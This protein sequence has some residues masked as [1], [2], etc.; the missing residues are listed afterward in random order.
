[1]NIN[2]YLPNE[3]LETGKLSEINI[4]PQYEKRLQSIEELEQI[5]GIGRATAYDMVINQHISSI[6]M[7]KS[8]YEKGH[9]ELPHQIVMGLKYHG[10]FKENIPRGEI[11]KIN[12]FVQK[13]GKGINKKLIV[14]IS[15][16]YRRGKATSNDIDILLSHPTKNYTREFVNKLKESGFIVD[17]LTDKDYDVKYMGF[18]KFLDNPVRR[19]DI[20][21]VPQESYYSALL[22]FTGPGNFNQQIR[23]LA[24]HLGY[25]LN[26]YG[27]YKLEGEKRIKLPINSEKDIFDALGLEY[28]EP[29]KRE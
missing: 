14:V 1:M 9:I 11:D 2:I 18:S 12:D 17:D 27:L 19:L 25:L 5:F 15:G 26:E 6:K 3:I 7:L 21:F 22:H 24:H 16:S 4:N 23:E 10:V 20:K 8:K 13:I 29:S 28:I